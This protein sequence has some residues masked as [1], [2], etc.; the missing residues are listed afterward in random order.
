MGVEIN[1]KRKPVAYHLYKNHP[2]DLGLQQ[3][4]E[5]IRV[6]AEE[7]IHAFV[8]Q[9]PEQTRGYPFVAP[10]MGNIKMLNGYFEAEITAARVASAKMGFFTSPACDG[11]VG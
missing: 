9:R 3:S 11:Y 8:R 7:V 6:P 10:V 4:N 2:N 1:D 5:A